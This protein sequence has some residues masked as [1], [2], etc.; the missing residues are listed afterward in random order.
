MNSSAW[1]VGVAVASAWMGAAGAYGADNA[2][3]DFVPSEDGAYVVDLRAKMAWPR[4]VEGMQWNG[5]TC[6]GKPERMDHS[7]AVQLAAARWK[8][9]GIAWR[10]PRAKELQ[11][12][13][14]G[15]SGK[16]GL[17]PVLFPAAPQDWHWSSTTNVKT[18][19]V[20]PYNYGDI[21]N[22]NRGETIDMQSGWAV[23]METGEIQGDF[24]KRTPM[25]VRLVRPLK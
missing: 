11:R 16:P 20:N 3:P 22:S 4:C 5:K 14:R 18:A 23:H 7:H 13:A 15:N 1:V 17:D 12:L 25:L 21:L 24:P 19:T 6:T 10:L 8:A 9:E 2:V